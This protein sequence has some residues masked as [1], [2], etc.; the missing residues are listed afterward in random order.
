M[1]KVI[2]EETGKALTIRVFGVTFEVVLPVGWGRLPV[3]AKSKRK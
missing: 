3:K 1:K 2:A